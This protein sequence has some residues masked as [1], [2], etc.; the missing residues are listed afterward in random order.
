[1][2]SLS[3]TLIQIRDWL[4]D[5]PNKLEK[6]FNPLYEFFRGLYLSFKPFSLIV[7]IIVV[8]FLFIKFLTPGS[9]ASF[10]KY[11]NNQNKLIEG[12]VISKEDYPVNLNPV[13]ASSSEMEKDLKVLIFSSL[14]R[15][16]NTGLLIP[17]AVRSWSESEDKKSYTI[18]LYDNIYWQDGEKFTVD[19]VFYTIN[20]IKEY[21]GESIHAESLK[22]VEYQRINDYK[23]KLELK[24]YNP[25]FVE[26]LVWGILPKHKL[27][28]LTPNEIK[29]AKFNMQPIGTGPFEFDSISEDKI[30][31][32][33]NKS[34]F[35][36]APKI[37]QLQF[38]L[39]SNE[40]ALKTDIAKGRIHTVFGAS[41]ETENYLTSMYPNLASDQSDPL[42]RRYWALYFNMSSDGANAEILKNPNIREALTKAIDV[43]YIV[44]N[45]VGQNGEIAYG[46]IA[47][48][49]WAFDDELLQ[50]K[51]DTEKAKSILENAGWKL[52][53]EGI[54]EK[55]G[56]KLELSLFTIGEPIKLAVVNEIKAELEEIGVKIN[57][58]EFNNDYLVNNFI[59]TRKYDL[60]FYGIETNSDPDRFPLWHSSQIKFPGLNLSSYESDIIDGRTEK[61]RVDIL[62]EKGRSETDQKERTDTYKTFQKYLSS[63]NPA[64]FIYHPK[65]S[66][67][68]NK[69]VK[70]IDI[71]N[72]GSA[73]Y[74]FWNIEDWEIEID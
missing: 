67:I 12:V 34:Y 32:I 42:Y 22:D 39:Y 54:R 15:T 4:W 43:D 58:E 61:S 3:N 33:S 52:N 63:E 46:T 44:K 56:K 73:E 71:A 17:D 18:E 24:N 69:R 2:A 47:K 26:N 51:S 7:P 30:N 50:R 6:I 13:F 11:L 19:D 59:A 37:K 16:D 31:L 48:T 36:G 25:T 60:L 70:N 53:A 65:V 38:N 23:F 45:I 27:E 9:L 14:F 72:I 74:R 62:L 66:Y 20:L 21:G 68:A 5:Y 41:K 35:K 57:I 28:D 64:V 1:M 55:A 8:S 10:D 29:R 49:S 40:D